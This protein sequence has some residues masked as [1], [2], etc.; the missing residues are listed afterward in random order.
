M[1]RLAG[2]IWEKEVLVVVSIFDVNCS[3][4]EPTLIGWGSWEMWPFDMNTS[5]CRKR[6]LAGSG[7]N[8]IPPEV[9]VRSNNWKTSFKSLYVMLFG[10]MVVDEMATSMS[11]D[12]IPVK[13]LRVLMTHW[14]L[15]VWCG[16]NIWANSSNSSSLSA[17]SSVVIA[18]G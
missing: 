7:N 8:G 5:T 1:N 17:G 18:L 6:L 16:G 12:E 13:W 15:A 9:G 11:S 4:E 14:E 2:G 10:S 3:V